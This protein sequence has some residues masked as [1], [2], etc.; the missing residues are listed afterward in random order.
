MTAAPVNDNRSVRQQFVASYERETGRVWPREQCDAC[1]GTGWMPAQGMVRA[2]TCPA[3]SGRG[4]VTVREA[5][6]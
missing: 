6:R 4:S 2:H 1:L 5:G 3:C